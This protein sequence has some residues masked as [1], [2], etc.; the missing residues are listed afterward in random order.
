MSKRYVIYDRYGRYKVPGFTIKS[1]LSNF[2]SGESGTDKK[3]RE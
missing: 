1:S 3:H 2:P